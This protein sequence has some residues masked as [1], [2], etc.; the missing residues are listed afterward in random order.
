[1]KAFGIG[2]LAPSTK[3]YFNPVITANNE[4]NSPVL[5][6]DASAGSGYTCEGA[7]VPPS[8][9]TA[10]RPSDSPIAPHPTTTDTFDIPM[11]QIDGSSF[12]LPMDENNRCV[13]ITETFAAA[14]QADQNLNHEIVIQAGAVCDGTNFFCFTKFRSRTEKFINFILV[15]PINFTRT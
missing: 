10:A 2:G 15:R 9:V 13:N 12:I 8:F 3:Y 7:G 11:P 6:S 1:M 5:C 14:A 4:I